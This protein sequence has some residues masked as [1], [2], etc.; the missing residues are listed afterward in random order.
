MAVGDAVPGGGADFG[1]RRLIVVAAPELEPLGRRRNPPFAIPFDEITAALLDRARPS[2][3]GF[4]LFATRFDAFQV[5]DRLSRLGFRGR[6]LALAPPL[7]RRKLVERELRGQAP[8]QKIRIFCLSSL[9]V[10]PP[11]SG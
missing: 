9:A 1:R 5:L 6:V 11:M 4:A 10:D 7:P 3:I 2:A 8:G